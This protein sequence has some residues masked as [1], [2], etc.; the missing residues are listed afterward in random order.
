MADAIWPQVLDDLPHVLDSP[1]F[2]AVNRD[3]E[4]SGA[5]LIHQPCMR[6]IREVWVGRAS[7]VD[8]DDAAPPVAERLLDDDGVQFQRERAIH[9]QNQPGT[10]LWIF[11][12]RAILPAN[13]CGD[14]MV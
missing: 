14:D 1:L 11:Q 10:H 6:A 3:A 4:A 12:Q 7:D 13:G 9:H 5:R 8:A 2:A